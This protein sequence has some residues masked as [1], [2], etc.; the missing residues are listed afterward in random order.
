VK[1]SSRK[2]ATHAKI[3]NSERKNNFIAGEDLCARQMLRKKSAKKRTSQNVEIVSARKKGSF[4]VV[5]KCRLFFGKDIWQLLFW[6][7]LKGKLITHLLFERSVPKKS[8]YTFCK[9]SRRLT[10]QILKQTNKDLKRIIVQKAL[11]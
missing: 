8:F 10:L 5:Y 3:A 6:T 1:I 2:V 4:F 7:G 11:R 9:N